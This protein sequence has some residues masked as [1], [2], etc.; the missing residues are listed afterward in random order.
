MFASILG[1]TDL[2]V[3]NGK[4][5]TPHLFSEKE[6]GRSLIPYNSGR[7]CLPLC[8]RA[9]SLSDDVSC[10]RER[11]RSRRWSTTHFSEGFAGVVRLWRQRPRLGRWAPR[12]AW[13][14]HDRLG[15]TYLGD[16]WRSKDID[17]DGEADSPAQPPHLKVIQRKHGHHEVKCV[18]DV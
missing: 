5:E 4:L 10:Y 11:E 16:P 9:S 18:V 15:H 2:K 13:Q 7:P 12:N 1:F 3:S 17:R 14:W 8:V 6:W